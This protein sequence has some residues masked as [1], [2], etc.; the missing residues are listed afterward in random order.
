MAT[1]AS[2]AAIEPQRVP[3]NWYVVVSFF[4]VDGALVC[5]MIV[6]YVLFTFSFSVPSYSLLL[7]CMPHTTGLAQVNSWHQSMPLLR[8]KKNAMSA[9]I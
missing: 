2:E 4:K 5:V 9:N 8:A 6:L 1:S 3:H 7:C